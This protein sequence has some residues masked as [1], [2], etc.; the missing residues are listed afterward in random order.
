MFTWPFSAFFRSRNCLPL[1]FFRSNLSS[2]MTPQRKTM[3]LHFLVPFQCVLLKNYLG[4]CKG[5][6][7]VFEASKKFFKNYK[8]LCCLVAKSQSARVASYHLQNDENI[9]ISIR[10]EWSDNFWVKKCDNI[11]ARRSEVREK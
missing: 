8:N 5:S 2:Q 6:R 7:Q 10:V 3:L 1:I 9:Q 4:W 11:E